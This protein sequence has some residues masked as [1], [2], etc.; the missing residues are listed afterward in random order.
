[1][2]DKILISPEPQTLPMLPLRGISVFPGMLL[3]FDVERPMSVAALNAALAADQLIFLVAQK[4][5]TK[6]QPGE[7]DIYKVG[8][9]CRLKQ[10]LRIPGSSVARVMVEGI[11]RAK[12]IKITSENPCFYAEVQP[13]MDKAEQKGSIKAEALLRQCCGLFEQYSQLSGALMPEL[14]LNLIASEDP[15]YAADYIAQNIYLKPTSKQMLLEETRPL[16]RLMLLNKFLDREIKILS[17]EQSLQES[18]QE[19]LNRSQREYFLREQLKV[20][21]AELGE[22]SDSEIDEYRE[23]ILKI[24]FDKE[25]EEKLLKEVSRLSKQPYGSSE[26]AVLRNYLDICL[27]LPWKKTTKEIVDIEKAR[28]I[29]D[30]DHYG[31]GKV[32]ERILEF[33]AVQQLAPDVKGGVLCLVGPPGTGK[34]SIAISIAKATNRRMSRISLGGVHDEAEIRG[35]RKTYVGAMPGR[36]IS[37]ILQA[38]SS[39]PLMVLDEIDKLGSDYRGDPSAALL[40]ALDT[41]QNHAFRDHYL[42]LPYDLSNVF[43]ICTANTTDTIPRALLDRMEVIELSSYTDEEKLQIAKNHL[44]KKQRKK[45]GLKASQLKISDDAIREIISLYTRESGVRV[46]ERQLA[47]VCRKAARGIAQGEYKT[48]NIKSGMLENFLGVP[49]YKPDLIH[50]ADEVGLVRGLAWTSVGG[51]VLEV[52]VG[53][54]EGSGKLELT[55]NLGDVMKESAKAAITYIRSRSGKLGIDPDFHKNRDIHIHF[56]EGAV[57]KDGPSAGITICIGVISALTGRPVRRDLAMT[58][59]ITL[60]GRILPVGGLKEK[61]MAALR[62]GVNSVIIPADNEKDLEEIDQSVRSALNFVTAD[63][64]DKILDVALNTGFKSTEPENV[65][66]AIMVPHSDNRESGSSVS[67]RQ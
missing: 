41:E 3:N 52:E 45:H 32:K 39:N 22:D 29:L 36:I 49:K 8:T 12:L 34:T 57:P 48:L 19:Q 59:E 27:E 1:M 14:L 44:L 11:C 25:I 67:I 35:H 17:M 62:S 64:V 51:E 58:G 60:R 5:I 38:K 31:L 55:G 65:G 30:A 7:S 40:E 20:I 24:G 23:R 21:Q 61:T 42:E 53:V 66:S 13:I 46:L 2:S 4:D 6:D 47:T 26:A 37:G 15:G 50:P 9:I 10:L 18:T 16:R 56:P 43:F 54:V 28:K 33:L 63:H